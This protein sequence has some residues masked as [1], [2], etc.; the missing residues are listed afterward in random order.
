ME[1]G[2][3]NF[4]CRYHTIANAYYSIN[5]WSGAGALLMVFTEIIIITLR[6]VAPK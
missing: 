5:L 1:F 6:L 3:I 2:R 4:D